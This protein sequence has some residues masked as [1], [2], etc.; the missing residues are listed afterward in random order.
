MSITFGSVGDIISV[1][2]LVKDLITALNDARG[3]PAEYQVLIQELLILDRTL[4]E[5][6]L[7]IR[8]HET[9][10]ELFALCETARQAVKACSGSVEKIRDRIKSY[11]STLSTNSTRNAITRGLDK[12]KWQISCKEDIVRFRAEIT[13]QSHSIKMLLATVMVKVMEMESSKLSQ[14]I[15]DTDRSTNEALKK[16]DAGIQEVKDR[17]DETNQLVAT[18]NAVISRLAAG[19]RLDWLSTL[20]MDIKK[21]TLA[22]LSMNVAI[23]RAITNLQRA[24]PSPPLGEERFILEDAIGRISPVPFQFISCWDALFAVL[25]IRFQELQGASKVRRREY[26]LQDRATGSDIDP[27]ERW[28]TSFQPGQH[29]TMSILFQQT[30]QRNPQAS[31]V[32]C[33]KCQLP[34]EKTRELEI[35]WYVNFST[36]NPPS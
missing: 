8:T 34:S 30:S 22:I 7:M 24:N 17:I 19:L 20:G 16:N 9:T 15:S 4:L 10:P 21:S 36:Y 5:V 27:S 11:G 28:E 3:A 29:V 32:I 14:A 23:Y 31:T 1:S 26:V 2:F 13:A 33:P 35:Q 25:E 6:E 18:G 12:A